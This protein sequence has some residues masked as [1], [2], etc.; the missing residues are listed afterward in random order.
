[1]TH[2]P[3]R[4]TIYHAR[5]CDPRK[6]SA[7]KLKRH[8]LVRVVYQLKLLPWGAV[9]LNPFSEKALSPAD[10]PLIE[11]RGLVALDYSWKC[12]EGTKAIP[13]VGKSRSLPYL[14]AANPVNFGKPTRLS[15]VEALAAA[16]YIVDHQEQAIQL[17][18]KFKW[19]PEFVRLNRTRLDEY[20]KAKDSTEVVAIQRK[21]M[22]EFSVS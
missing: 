9:V 3:I 17:L 10:R 8:G 2:E 13:M 20:A 4:I 22:E 6:C 18:S 16:L 11:A 14:V 12:T 5:Q 19:G 21:F 15:T 7:L 1:M